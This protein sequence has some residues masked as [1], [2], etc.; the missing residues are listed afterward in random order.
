M[1]IPL[2]RIGISCANSYQECKLLTVLTAVHLVRETAS[3]VR[4]KLPIQ[5]WL[6]KHHAQAV[7]GTHSCGVLT[8]PFSFRG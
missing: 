5:L 3:E 4:F 8:V 2:V 6:H 1:L 7:Q